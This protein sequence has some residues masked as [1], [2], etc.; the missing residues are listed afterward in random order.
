MRIHDIELFAANIRTRTK[1]ILVQLHLT[2]MNAA[3]NFD[4]TF[5]AGS[6]AKKYFA[7]KFMTSYPVS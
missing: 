6:A 7:V 3:T 5:D 4:N 2:T 1:T